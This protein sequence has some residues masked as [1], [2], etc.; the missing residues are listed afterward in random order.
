MS[1]YLQATK[2][3]IDLHGTTCSYIQTVEGVYNVDTSSITNTETTYSVKM[4][5]KHIKTDQYNYPDLIGREAAIFYLTNYALS[6]V[7]KMADVVLFDSERFNIQSIQ[8][9][10][11]AGQIVLYKLVAVK[12]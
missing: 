3:Q 9:H 2:R 12:G 7:P 8:E 11:A 4:Y 1:Q 6:F 5:K 10:R